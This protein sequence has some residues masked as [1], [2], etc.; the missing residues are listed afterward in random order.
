M[1]VY[2][3]IDL[4][5]KSIVNLVFQMFPKIRNLPDVFLLS[6]WSISKIG[7]PLALKLHINSFAYEKSAVGLE[8]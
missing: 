6:T 7:H 2:I 4:I 8:V 1:S 3:V 5:I